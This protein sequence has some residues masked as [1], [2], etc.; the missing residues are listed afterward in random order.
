MQ[1]RGD[2]KMN[3]FHHKIKIDFKVSS[4][5]LSRLGMQLERPETQDKGLLINYT[6]KL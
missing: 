6:A 5:H 2:S 4:R 1:G 3:I